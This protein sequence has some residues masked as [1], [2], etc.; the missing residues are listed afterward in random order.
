MA[1]SADGHTCFACAPPLLLKEN[2]K[3]NLPSFDELNTLGGAAAGATATSM[4]CHH[5][6][7]ASAAPWTFISFLD[8]P[9][10]GLRDHLCFEGMVCL[11]LYL[12]H[13]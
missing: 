8:V 13:R 2:M 4:L 10:A 3:L 7:S 5:P 11:S 6:L 1:R 9:R 12:P